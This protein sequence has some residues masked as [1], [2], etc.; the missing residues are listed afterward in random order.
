[1]NKYMNKLNYVLFVGLL[2]SVLEYNGRPTDYLDSANGGVGA[3]MYAAVEMQKLQR[4][5]MLNRI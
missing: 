3:V 5:I 2:L 4:S 1:M